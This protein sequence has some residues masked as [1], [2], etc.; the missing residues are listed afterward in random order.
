MAYSIVSIRTGATSATPR[1]C[2]SSYPTGSLLHWEHM[3]NARPHHL[4]L[5]VRTRY[6][7][8]SEASKEA[9][10]GSTPP[11]TTP[12]RVVRHRTGAGL[13]PGTYVYRRYYTVLGSRCHLLISL[14]YIVSHDEF[15]MEKEPHRSACIYHRRR[16]CRSSRNC[17][18]RG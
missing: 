4:K 10:H 7:P 17:G 11:T 13:P 1:T 12:S 6:T 14:V 15:T 5:Y 18:S 16:V 2:T 9:K 8:L 3:C